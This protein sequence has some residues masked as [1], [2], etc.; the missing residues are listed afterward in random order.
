MFSVNVGFLSLPQDTTFSS[1]VTALFLRPIFKILGDAGNVRSEGRISFEKT[2]WLTLAGSS[3]A[4]FSSTAIYING[5][6]YVVLGG[7]GKPFWANPYLNVFVFGINLH[8]AVI[9]KITF[10]SATTHLRSFSAT[11]KKSRKVGP[12]APPVF[13]SNAY[14]RP[15]S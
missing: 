8:S 10:G 9:K 1:V 12:A 2:K 7:Y 14:D 3:L 6:L 4:V 11:S 5:G 15:D 13:D